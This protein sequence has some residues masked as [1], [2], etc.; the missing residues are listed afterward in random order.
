MSRTVSSFAQVLT[1]RR[2][3]REMVLPPALVLFLIVLIIL[4]LQPLGAAAPLRPPVTGAATAFGLPDRLDAPLWAKPLAENPPGRASMVFGGSRTEFVGFGDI[5]RFGS[6]GPAGYRMSGH[7]WDSDEIHLGE[8]ILLSPDGTQVVWAETSLR[9]VDLATGRSR[10]VPLPYPGQRWAWYAEGPHFSDVLA[11][12]PDGR[13]LAMAEVDHHLQ[14]TGLSI[15]D[16]Q[17]GDYRRLASV[18]GEL[19]PGFGAAFSPDGQRIAYQGG[20]QLSIVDI[21]GTPV[22]SRT[23]QPGALLAG[24]GAW[25]PDGSAIAIAVPAHCCVPVNT[26]WNLRFIAAGTGES[27]ADRGLPTIKGATAVR[28]L[29]WSSPTRPVLIAF[30]PE[31]F[32]DRYPDLDRTS[33]GNVQRV[34]IVALEPGETPAL[35]LTSPDQVLSIDVAAQAIAGGA[36]VPAP[37]NPLIPPTRVLI[38]FGLFTGIVFLIVTGFVYMTI[39]LSRQPP[40]NPM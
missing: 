36:I 34:E 21:N 1:A 27:A 30:R 28:L 16:V 25:T 35:L 9:I 18:D 19:V 31:L 24:K 14:W 38:G 11:W 40:M 20:N 6:V 15:V 17:T 7:W 33:F 12:S 29:G 10:Q 5:S 32:L 22:S 26:D 8:E 2:R 3:L 4:T 13:W 37:P 23:L 39:R